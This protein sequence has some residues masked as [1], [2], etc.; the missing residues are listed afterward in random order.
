MVK[1]VAILE[2]SSGTLHLVLSKDN[3]SHSDARGVAET[4]SA[5]FLKEVRGEI[6]ELCFG[7]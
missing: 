4:F 5:E 7:G 1:A 3:L 2:A 6:S